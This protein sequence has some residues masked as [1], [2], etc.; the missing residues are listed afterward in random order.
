MSSKHVDEFAESFAAFIRSLGLLE[1]DR[2]PCGA[3][4]SVAEAHALTILRE[5]AL[6]QGKLGSLLNLGK[7][8]TS[9]LTDG[10][11]ERGWVQREPDPSDGRARL[12]TLTEA[13]SNAAESVVQRRSQRLK[14]LLDHIDPD[15]HAAV[16]NA[17]R[18]L[19]EASEHDR[20]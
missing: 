19:K 15:Q 14:A 16:I 20:R 9:R 18:L 8:T 6:H 12:L 17:L 10:L 13:G 2:T 11:V 3:P 1:P 7:S 5:G 4:M